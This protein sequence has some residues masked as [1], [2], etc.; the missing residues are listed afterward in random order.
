MFKAYK[1][2]YIMQN[3]RVD[4]VPIGISLEEGREITLMP[5]QSSATKFKY[6]GTTAVKTSWISGKDAI[7]AYD[8]DG[9]G[10]VHDGSKIVLTR[11]A[12]G[13]ESDFDALLK[14]FDFN[15]NGV[16]DDKDEAFAKFGLWQDKNENGMCEEGEFMSLQSA[17]ISSIDFRDESYSET[18]G[19]RTA[20]VH[21]I[22][23]RATNAYDLTFTHESAGAEVVE[24]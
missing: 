24:I 17:G 10:C 23:G 11:W 5:L 19:V 4:D 3:Q 12:N 7:L 6:D 18:L 14:V 9:S 8:H 15:G 16:F 1:A 20:K 13:T 22:D 2:R 21:W